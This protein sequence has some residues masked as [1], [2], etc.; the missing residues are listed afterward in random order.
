MLIGDEGVAKLC[1]FGSS[2][3]ESSTLRSIMTARQ[4]T[5]LWM[6]PEVM[7]KT[8]TAYTSKCDVYSFAIVMWEIWARQLPFK[9]IRFDYEIEQMVLRGDRPPMNLLLP[10]AP[11]DAVKLMTQSWV[12][13]PDER[14]TSMKLYRRFREL[15]KE[16]E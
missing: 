1:D 16:H 14:P 12:R 10:T 9:D 7:V 6:A 13:E 2:R 5:T 11:P 3:R 4:G 8:F 15:R